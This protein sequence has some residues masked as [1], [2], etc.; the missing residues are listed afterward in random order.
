MTES[1]LGRVCQTI[2]PWPP[3]AISADE[4]AAERGIRVDAETRAK[5]VSEDIDRAIDLERSERRKRK[6]D[7]KILLLGECSGGSP[8]SP[9]PYPILPRSSRVG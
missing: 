2:E 7:I 1:R 8:L 9:F 5:K 6:P 4:T 3:V